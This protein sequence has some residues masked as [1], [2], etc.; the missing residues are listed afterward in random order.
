MRNKYKHRQ[1]ALAVSAT[2]LAVLGTV[3]FLGGADAA[4]KTVRSNPKAVKKK[5]SAPVGRTG[6]RLGG[7]RAQEV[8]GRERDDDKPRPSTTPGPVTTEKD[9][10]DPVVVS[11][12]TVA[13]TTLVVV[14]VPPTAPPTLPPVV[15]TVA[16]TVPATKPVTTQVMATVPATVATTVPGTTAT[17]VATTVATTLAPTTL[18]PT[19]VAPTTAGATTTTTI[20]TTRPPTTLAPTTVAPTTLAPTTLAPTT[21]APTTLAPTTVAPTTLAPAPWSVSS[22][23]VNTKV[24]AILRLDTTITNLTSSPQNVTVLVTMSSTGTVPNF[25]VAGQVASVV[26]P[27]WANPLSPKKTVCVATGAGSAGYYYDAPGATSTFSCSATIP[28]KTSQVLTVSTGS[29]IAPTDTGTLTAGVIV[30]PGGVATGA[31]ATYV[32]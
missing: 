18:V 23:F 6:T 19:T 5:T 10:D 21:V 4:S 26:Q 2:A 15:P 24:G 20:A 32:P 1:T 13:P 3:P 31:S 17:S 27:F 9:D 30:N 22:Q 29:L 25:L 7:D 16:S 12:T 14:S 11:P 28:A 8:R